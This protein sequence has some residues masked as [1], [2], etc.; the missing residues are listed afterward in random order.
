[1]QHFGAGNI[2]RDLSEKSYLKITFQSH[3]FDVNERIIDALNERQNRL[4]EE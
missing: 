3:S 2:G 4:V 1:M